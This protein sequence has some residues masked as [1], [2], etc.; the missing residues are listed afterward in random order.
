MQDIELRQHLIAQARSLTALGLSQGTS[1]NLSAR[2]GEAM[3]ITPS[4]VPYEAL[5]PASLALMPLDGA[6]AFAGPLKPSSE[7]RFHLDIFRARPDVGA[8]VHAHSTYATVLS[9]LRRPIKAV[10]YMIAALGGPEIACT[11]YAPFGTQALSDLVIAGLGPRHGVLLG[12]H[13]MIAT[14]ADLAQAMHRAVEL[15]TLARQS[16]LAGLA[17]TPVILPDDEIM[18]C[19]ER[20]KTYG[21]NAGDGEA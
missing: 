5:T 11:D 8:I 9:I 13:G 4:G 10:H 17:G 18:R 21:P 16:Y 12:N 2:V 14:G 19:V 1:G 20:F 7:W 3:L 15:E 6:G